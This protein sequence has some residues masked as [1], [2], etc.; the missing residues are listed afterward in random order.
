[1]QKKIF[2]HILFLSFFWVPAMI[3]AQPAGLK[4]SLLE[5]N[6]AFALQT[7][8]ILKDYLAPDFSVAT[9]TGEYA[10]QT[11]AAIL[12]NYRLDSLTYLDAK[13]QAAGWMVKV[14]VHGG[15]TNHSTIHLDQSFRLLHIGLADQLYGMN[16][17]TAA[18][19][20]AVIPFEVHNGSIIVTVTINKSKRPLRLLFDTGADGMMLGKSLADSIGLSVSYKNNASVAGGSIDIDVS[21]NNNVHFN[22]F[23]LDG[24]SIAIFDRLGEGIDGILGNTVAQRYITAVNYAK[25]EITL[26]SFGQFTPPHNAHVVPVEA[27][28][29]NIKINAVLSIHKEKPLKASFIFDTGAGYELIV[30]RPFVLKHKLLVDNFRVDSTGSTMSLGVNSPVFFGKAAL[31]EIPPSIRLPQLTVALM[32]SAGGT[33]GPSHIDGSLGVKFISRY[34]FTINLMDK[35]IVFSQRDTK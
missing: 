33:A 7:D 12:K 6:R 30:F 17:D 2:R 22:G 3:Q 28:S 35:Y 4:Q 25:K 18:K 34:N 32:G 9:Y 10:R 27:N 29:G 31:L 1:M 23:T 8:S 13:Q 15:R 19:K 16:R 20:L 21:E 11:L 5:L 14:K 26:Y 24:Q